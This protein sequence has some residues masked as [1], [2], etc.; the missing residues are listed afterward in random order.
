[1][2]AVEFLKQ[3]KRMCISNNCKECPLFKFCGEPICEGHNFDKVVSDMEKW[4][5]EH[6]QKTRLQDL[7]EKYPNAA[8]EIRGYPTFCCADLG[9]LGGCENGSTCEQC[10]NK[11][12]EE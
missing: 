5:E 4:A 3:W 6:P 10:W 2:E 11:P 1:M 9:Y 8:M 7:L 12:V